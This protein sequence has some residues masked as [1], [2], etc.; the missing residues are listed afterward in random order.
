MFRRIA[1]VFVLLISLAG[2]SQ[3]KKVEALTSSERNAVEAVFQHVFLEEGGIYTLWGDK[4]MTGF[5]I[6]ENFRVKDREMNYLSLQDWVIFENVIKGCKFRRFHLFKIPREISI[7]GAGSYQ[8]GYLVNVPETVK[9]IRS[10]YDVFRKT[11]GFDFDPLEQV[12]T[13]QNPDSLFWEKVLKN[14]C[15][16]GILFG[17]GDRNA[18]LFE[19]WLDGS[20]E[21]ISS[22]FSDRPSEKA[23]IQKFPLPV[24]R[25]FP[26]AENERLVE[27]YR[28]QKRKIQQLYEEEDFVLF[29][30]SNLFS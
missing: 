18:S 28:Q 10:H 8:D 7:S 16:L 12:L 6:S 17:Y 22:G 20:R 2:C 4:P 29:T 25:M 24:F 30:L 19:K 21:N 9:T 5:I 23:T 15:L 13:M 3:G 26:S 14:K 11:V 1:I 27:K